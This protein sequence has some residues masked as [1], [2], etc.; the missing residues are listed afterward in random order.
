MGADERA[1]LEHTVRAVTSTQRDALRAKIALAAADGEPTWSIAMRLNTS[2]DTVSCWR[3]RVARFGIEGLQD[4][5]RSG[6]TPRITPVQR[7]EI[8][9][10]A[11]EPRSTSEGLNGWT[12][13]QLRDEIEARQITTISR[14]HLHRVL[15]RADLHPHK[16]KMWVHS[17]DPNFREKVAE[18]VDLYMNP[19]PGSTVL[20]IDEKTG[21]QAIE[22][23]H[24]DRPAKPG[25]LARREFEYIR[26]GTQSLLAS[27]RVH[28]GEVIA[29]CGA[30]RKGED[31]EAFMEEVARE[32]P[33]PIEVIWD[34]LNIHHGDRWEKF[35]RR[36][37]GRFRFH[38]T[39]LHASWVNQIEMWFGIL[40]KRCLTNGSFGSV[41]ALRDA[42]DAFVT[43]WNRKAKHPFRW[44]FTGYGKRLAKPA[45]EEERCARAT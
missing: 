14:S 1:K 45:G 2:V 11:C 20:C 38:Y 37:S 36:H 34:N 27:F 12:L 10:I 13:D 25:Q 26:H 5:P 7:C 24:P 40:Q 3:K 30:T 42:V 4:R 18:V 19:P 44:S 41:E 33:G 28:T 32:V 16:K 43:Y 6:C 35:S 29:R 17:P 15:Q 31:L 9:S 23:K 21:M 8:V 39:P 22:R